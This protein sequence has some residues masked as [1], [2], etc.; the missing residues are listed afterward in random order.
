MLFMLLSMH[1]S[2]NHLI[3]NEGSDVVSIGVH[4]ESGIEAELLRQFVGDTCATAAAYH[5]VAQALSL[6]QLDEV[7]EVMDMYVFLRD[8]LRDN[9]RIGVE[10]FAFGNKLLIRHL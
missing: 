7:G 10:L 9:E 8:G 5:L 1:A 4:T 2:L 3:D 6:H